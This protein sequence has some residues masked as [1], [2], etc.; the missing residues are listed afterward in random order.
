MKRRG[1]E[2][3]C[4]RCREVKTKKVDKNDTIVV[5]RK[6]EASKGI[7]YFISIE[8]KDK[9]TIIG[10]TRLRFNNTNEGVFFNEL[11]DSAIIRE[12]H[13]Y[14]LVTNLGKFE[15]Q[16]YQHHGY[17]KLLLKTAE[18]IARKKG[19]KKI[20]IISG[21][22]VRGYYEKRGYTLSNTYMVK[23]LK[24]VNNKV[25]GLILITIAM[26]IIFV[27]LFF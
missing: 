11:N 2:C 6:F 7:E 24:N 18:N 21:V 19:Y 4:I 23:N 16:K 14:G 13:V 25:F 12:L 17:G 8:T 27:K 22:G 5:I 10:F 26:I 20:S 15:S 3:E 9:K 1:K